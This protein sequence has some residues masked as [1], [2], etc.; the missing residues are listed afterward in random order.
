MESENRKSSSRKKLI[1]FIAYLSI[2]MLGVYITFY[3]YTI[4]NLTQLL[5]L[6]I[7]MMGML[8][9]MQHVGISIPPIFIGTLCNKI[10]KKKVVLLSYGLII[11][12]TFFTG[13]SKN[14]IAVASSVFIIGAGFSVTE[15]T[16]SAILADE[17]PD[18]S[19][20]HISFSQVAFSVGALSGPF[21]AKALIEG[22]VFFK[23]LYF[24][25]SAVFLILAIIFFFTKY[26]NDK[27]NNQNSKK[28]FNI[29]KFLNIK[30]FLLLALT[31]FMYVGIENT[32]A[33]FADSYFELELIMPQFSATALALFWGAMIP[34]RLLAGIIKFE[35]KKIFVFM[36]IIVFITVISA[37]IVPNYYMKI[38]MFALCGFA[39]GPLWPIIMDTTAKKNKGSTGPAL[40]VMMA[41]SGLGGALL[42]LL[43][44]AVVE[45]TKQSAAYYLSALVVIITLY[46]Y[47]SAL[48]NKN[49]T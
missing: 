3:Q 16:L 10:G 13:V 31:I 45:F 20:K 4:L 21:L 7:T 49:K 26:K 36:S 40:N 34:S 25:N 37:M 8:I 1:V 38:A 42:P 44:G 35:A 22:G 27:G 19:T 24:F 47:L 18:E 29:L 9:A 5:N 46:L 39:C 14:F 23:N 15:G 30:V 12:G 2:G 11:L 41:F 48:N 43:S 33:N 28:S 6:N 32:I 17:F